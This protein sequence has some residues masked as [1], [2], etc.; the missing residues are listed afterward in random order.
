MAMA[1]QPEKFYGV[2]NHGLEV[3]SLDEIEKGEFSMLA[4]EATIEQTYYK[5]KSW[6]GHVY[7][8]SNMALVD[9]GKEIST[10]ID[11]ARRFMVVA[12]EGDVSLFE[13]GEDDQVQRVGS[14]LMAEGAGTVKFR[15]NYIY[16]L[17]SGGLRI[18][19][20]VRPEEL[21]T[22]GELK[23]SGR[24]THFEVLDSRYLLV[25]TLDNGVLVVDVNTPQQPVEVARLVLPQ[26]LH[27]DN[28]AQAVLIDDQRAYI[29]QG[30]GGVHVVDVSVPTQPELLQIIETPG[31]AKNMTFYDNLLLVAD[32]A[33]GVFMIDI[34]DRNRALPIGSLPTPIRVSQIA[35]TE[36]GLIVSGHQGGTM[37]LPLPQ[38][39]Q[40]LQVIGV[41]EMRVDV[42]SLEKGQYVYLYD[43]WTS[44]QVRVGGQVQVGGL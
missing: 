39:L 44:G 11:T 14:F 29:S 38:R 23:L 36:D 16:M 3:F 18:S 5:M 20:G 8:Y 40:N 41:D 12:D 32:G 31:F 27:R 4:T 42:E 26:H 28:V 15:D 19:F 24:C 13:Q 6:N 17:H 22:I 33:K 2:S 35:V 37:K 21:V 25:T 10:D 34:K 1:L 30:K 43:E 9:F 7:G